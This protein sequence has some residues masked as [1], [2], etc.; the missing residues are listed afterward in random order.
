MRE[1]FFDLEGVLIKSVLDE[2]VVVNPETTIVLG[3]ARKDF[4]NTMVWTRAGISLAY[5]SLRQAN[6][7]SYLDAVIG[8]DDF[9][10]KTNVMWEIKDGKRSGE[11]TNLGEVTPPKN[12][13]IFGDP[14]SMVLIED[15]QVYTIEDVRE[16]LS[17]Q[18][19][20]SEKVAREFV[21]ILNGSQAGHPKERV[22]Y[23]KTYSGQRGH[24]LV[25]AYEEALRRF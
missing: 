16:K 23:I 14:R 18:G 15:V 2:P 10:E 6:L 17:Y 11:I 19:E 9:E 20:Y 25:G 13:E 1:I 21:E 4:K 7:L 24:D 22:V 3:R 12:L 5:D 8:G